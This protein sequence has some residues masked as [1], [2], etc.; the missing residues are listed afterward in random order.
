MASLG[1][2]GAIG[3]KPV[4]TTISDKAVPCPLDHVNR[5]FHA[6]RPMPSGSRTS[7]TRNLVGLVYVAFVIDAY[8]RRIV[9]G[10]SHGQHGEL[11]A[12][13][14]EQA[15]HPRHA[16]AA[17]LYITRPRQPIRLDQVP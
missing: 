3:G 15:L 4:R 5:Q 9:G 14:L 8:A 6:L 16:I 13:A 11:R 7:P 12:D 10:A 17:G 1:L 2:Q